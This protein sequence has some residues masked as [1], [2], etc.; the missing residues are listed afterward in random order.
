MAK[1][2]EILIMGADFESHDI[3]EQVTRLNLLH[4]KGEITEKEYDKEIDKLEDRDDEFALEISVIKKDNKHGHNSYGWGGE[5][6]IILW[7]SSGA[8]SNS[9]FTGNIV[10]CKKVAELLCDNMNKKGM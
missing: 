2:W 1:V 5:S 9:M 8:I 7:D 10:W 3:F 4:E 6:K